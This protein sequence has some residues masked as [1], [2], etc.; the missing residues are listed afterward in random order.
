[1]I[2]YL[3]WLACAALFS[4]N[5]NNAIGGAR[6]PDGGGGGIFHDA[7]GPVEL[8]KGARFTIVPTRS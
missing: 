3:G 4:G 7:D 1:M 5:D 2:A 8:A 6:T